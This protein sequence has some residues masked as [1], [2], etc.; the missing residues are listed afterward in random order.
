[1]Q[2]SFCGKYIFIT[3]KYKS[4]LKAVDY[5]LANLK[6]NY[7]ENYTMRLYSHQMS[8]SLLETESS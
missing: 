7:G 5:E 8:S 1:M 6:C 4:F 2:L 3:V